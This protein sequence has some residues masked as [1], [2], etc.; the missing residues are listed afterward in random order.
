MK[1]LNSILVKPAGPDCNLACGYCFYLEK[2]ALFPETRV[3][4]MSDE[5]LEEMIRQAMAQAGPHIAFGWQGGEPTLMGLPFFEKAV[6]L[7]KKHGTRQSVG[8]G[9][10]T[11]GLLIDEAWCRHLAEYSYLVGLSLDGPEHIHDR[12]RRDRGGKGTF[13]RVKDSAK[14]M[15]D[16]GVAVNALCVVNDYSVQYP[17][18][19]YF[20]LKDLGLS[21]MQFIP[22]VERDPADPEKTAACTV[23][24]DK[25]GRFLCT[26]FDLWLADFED[27]APFTSI[28]HFDSI[29]HLY[30]GRTAPECTLLKECGIYVVVEHNGDVYACDFFVEPEWKLGNVMEGDLLEM[31]NSDQQQA[32]GRLKAE[33]PVPCEVC[34]W[35]K[36]CRGGCPKDRVVAFREKRLDL[37]CLAHKSFLEHAHPRF[38]EL[39]KQ[40]KKQ[41]GVARQ[42]EERSGK[43]GRN[44]P[45]PCGSGKKYK[46]CCG[47]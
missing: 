25:Y 47:N 3:H 36:Y 7:Q 21:Y 19:I 43:P 4:R 9:L 16:A 17:E 34:P 8:N 31:L 29:F 10:Q 44:D 14:R 11:N 42:K 22:V 39:A 12:Y 5:V 24:P 23:P 26:L 33:L 20:F 40:W 27:G 30:A 41:Q 1:P 35:L 28:R 38:L 37:L 32:F 46:R 15:L 13:L 45:C 2:E 6:A 18:E